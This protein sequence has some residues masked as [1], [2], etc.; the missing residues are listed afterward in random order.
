MLKN[1]FIKN[2]ALI[3]ELEM[4]PDRELSIITGETGAGKSIMLGAIGLLLGHRADTKAL[5]DDKEKCII[6]GTFE[7]PEHDSLKNIFAE[8]ELDYDATNIIRREISPSGKSR[9]FVNDTPVTLE[10]LKKIGSMLVDIHS[11]HDTLQLGSN[12]YQ[13]QIIDIYAQN[14]ILITNYLEAFKSFKKTQAE[15]N[16]LVSNAETLHKELDYN[17]FLLNEL[18]N[19]ELISDQEIELI[20]DELRILESAEEI[21]SKLVNSID[22]LS[23]SENSVINNLRQSVSVLNQIGNISTRHRN[24]KDRLESC[25]I[26]LKDVI[27]ELE[28]EE[29]TVDLDPEKVIQIQTRLDFIYRL[30]KKHQVSKVQG[31]IELR[32]ELEHKVSKILNF[33]EEINKVKLDLDKNIKNVNNLGEQLSDSRKSVINTFENELIALLTEVGMPNASV[34]I[35][36]TITQP[37]QTG[38]DTIN[39]LFSANKGVAPADLKS[40]ASGGE[41]SR[42]MLCVKYV[43]AAKTSLPTIIFD[44][45]DTG[46]SGEIAIRVGKMIKNMASH[47]HQ[48]IAIS[49]LHQI[50]ANGNVHYFVYK[51]NSSDKTISKIKK[52]NNDERIFEI[53]KMIGGEKP[54]ES[55]MISAK[56]MLDSN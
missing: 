42:L 40:V 15:Y 28:A 9:A 55:A 3:Q 39:L 34:K 7:V 32:N 27:L 8:E 21:K 6:E 25:Y 51:D 52:L 23:G 2:Y 56:E 37:T 45:I 31:L 13:L 48:V 36:H 14:Q 5:F 35:K 11:Q 18:V 53:A 47:R 29:N 44:E 1:L 20:E 17:Q 19:A 30:Q 16:D 4:K 38:I 41:F 26:E 54:S 49:H 33:D 10:I 46:I 12:E 24:L 22:I 43:L 50:A